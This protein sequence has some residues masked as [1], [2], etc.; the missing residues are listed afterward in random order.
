V[1]IKDMARI[2]RLLEIKK[3]KAEIEITRIAAGTAAGGVLRDRLLQS[4]PDVKLRDISIRYV[5]RTVGIIDRGL[6][7]LSEQSNKA[8][9]ELLRL[10]TTMANLDSRRNAYVDALATHEMEEQLIEAVSHR[11]GEND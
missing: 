7:V 10:E 1:T 3:K 9:A 4:E 5:T 8:K 11:Q 2:T 6:V